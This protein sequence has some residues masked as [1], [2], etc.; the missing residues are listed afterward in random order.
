[1]K[2]IKKKWLLPLVLIMVLSLG[3]V[4][5][6]NGAD[7]TQTGDPDVEDKVDD[8]MDDAKDSVDDTVK[9]AEDN[10]RDMNYEDIK[11]RPE[12][13]FDKFMELHA[14]TKINQFDLD[15]ELMEYQY[16]IEGYDNDNEYEVK[17]NPVDGEVLSDDSQ[18]LDMDDE[19]IEIT[20]DHVSKVDSIIDKAKEEDGS[21][22][23]LDEW[24]ISV[25]DG[26]VVIDIEIGA[27]E[28]SYDMETE[29]LIEDEM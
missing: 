8:T 5:C 20:K 28:Y 13:A 16:V 23:E 27:T 22:S 2:N 6:T 12:E 29:E 15:K 1:M 24:S 26:K 10:V 14:G 25:E 9:E 3:L 7:D 21:D 4:A 18:V 17:M 19:N 11:I